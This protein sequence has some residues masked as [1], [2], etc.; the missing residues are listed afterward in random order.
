MVPYEIV[1]SRTI[2]APA[3]VLYPLIADYQ[4]GHQRIMPRRYFKSLEVLAGG[5]GAG[6]RIRFVI[7][8]LGISQ[9]MH[10]EIIEPEPGR[11]LHERVEETGAVTTFTLTPHADGRTTQVT[12]SSVLQVRKG[13]LG[14]IEGR[15]MRWIVTP[16]FQ[17]ELQQLEEV[18]C[19]D[20]AG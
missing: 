16:I 5:Y 2:S 19:A 12:I 11:I 8:V 3:E 1:A 9:T 14:R 18:A 13:W 17:Q 15:L 7:R 10:A 6:T 4:T 20:A